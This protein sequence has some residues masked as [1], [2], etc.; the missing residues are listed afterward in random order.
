MVGLGPFL[1]T[2]KALSDIKVDPFNLGYRKKVL[3]GSIAD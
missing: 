3:S 1:M 2:L